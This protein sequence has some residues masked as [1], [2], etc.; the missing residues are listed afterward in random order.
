[1][2]RISD[3]NL[4]LS[5]IESKLLLAIVISISYFFSMHSHFDEVRE[6]LE[7]KQNEK[8]KNEAI[9]D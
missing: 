1:M 3:L 9:F 2:L 5:Q 8:N 7:E 6:S 4:L